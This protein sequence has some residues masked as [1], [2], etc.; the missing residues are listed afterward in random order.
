MN[1]ISLKI[2]NLKD[3]VSKKRIKVEG[4][5]I[6]ELIVGFSWAKEG[7][8]FDDLY[9]ELLS[10]NCV[11]LAE[12]ENKFYSVFTSRIER[13]GIEEPTTQSVVR[14]PREGFSEDIA[15]NILII[16]KR[17]NNNSLRMINLNVG[18]VCKTKVAIMY[19]EGI[20]KKDIVNEVKK[21]I[22]KIKVDA[23][24][25][26]SY[27]EELTKDDPYSVF[28]TYLSLEKSDS[29]SAALLQ[30]KVAI[31][32]DGTPFVL[33]VPAVFFDFLQS[34]EDYY[35]HYIVASM[36]R[37]IRFITFYFVLLVPS[38]YVAITT[39]HQE[40]LPT[41]LLINIAAQREDVPFPVLFETFLMEFTFEILC[42]AGI[43]I[44]RAIGA[45]ISVVGG[46]VIGQ[47]AVE[48][49][50][51][52]AAVVIVV[53]FTAISSFSIPNYE[54]SSAL[55]AVRFVFMILAGALGLYG[56][57]MGIIILWL[58][59]CK[60]KSVTVPYVTPLTPLIPRENKDTLIRF[61]LMEN[62]KQDSWNWKA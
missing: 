38:A 13:R 28:P 29:V 3:E 44:P 45:A 31:L 54:M 57:F 55:R 26:S 6:K 58:H 46:V 36:M 32:V 34:S 62:K 22:E 25:D 10:G 33:T 37:I 50:I 9:S 8:S 59:L 60:I 16:K 2:T 42:E 43:R 17:I 48:A 23:V 52:S 30:G 41:A 18:R 14:G 47:V 35:H 1:D 49:G 21:R 5:A 11:F 56:L 19:I 27:I 24:H 7:R 40:I 15:K 12:G 53:S 61:P 4:A 20:A 39:Y 51:M